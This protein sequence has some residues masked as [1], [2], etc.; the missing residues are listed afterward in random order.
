[1][2]LTIPVQL[3]QKGVT[4]HATSFAQHCQKNIVAQ[5]NS[6]HSLRGLDGPGGKKRVLRGKLRACISRF[7]KDLT[8]GKLSQINDHYRHCPA[9]KHE[10]SKGAFPASVSKS[11]AAI[12]VSKATMEL[13]IPVQLTQKGVTSH[14]TSFAQALPEKHCCSK[15]FKSLP[16]CF[17]SCPFRLLV[18]PRAK[19]SA[20]KKH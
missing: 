6:N 7:L 12:R 11:V 8:S 3:T 17:A 1:M 4:S 16:Y 9:I 19:S 18:S 20:K 5:N 2:E 14:A 13:T 15:Q 10:R